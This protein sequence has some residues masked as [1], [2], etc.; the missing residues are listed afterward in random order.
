MGFF[1]HYK[2]IESNWKCPALISALTFGEFIPKWEKLRY[3]AE[4]LGNPLVWGNFYLEK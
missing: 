4:T 3:F 1:I 2:K